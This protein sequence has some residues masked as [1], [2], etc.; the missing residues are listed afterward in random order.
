MRLRRVSFLHGMS[1]EKGIIRR[2]GF[3]RWSF[4][5]DMVMKDKF[6]LWLGGVIGIYSLFVS[7]LK[8]FDQAGEG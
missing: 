6:G 2:G 8:L 7:C 4:W 1:G 3:F 5:H